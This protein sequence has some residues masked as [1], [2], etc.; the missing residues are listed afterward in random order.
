MLLAGVYRRRNASGSLHVARSAWVDDGGIV[1]LLLPRGRLQPGAHI[2]D[3]LMNRGSVD[4]AV[5]ERGPNR[6]IHAS[7]R[8]SDPRAWRGARESSRPATRR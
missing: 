8:S 1:D 3:G 4:M 2:S 7:V 6:A 5:R